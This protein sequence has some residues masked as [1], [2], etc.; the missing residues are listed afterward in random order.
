MTKMLL[1]LVVLP[2]LVQRWEMVNELIIVNEIPV[3]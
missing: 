3:T 2:L 1:L